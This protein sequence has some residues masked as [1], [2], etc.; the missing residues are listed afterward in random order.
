MLKGKTRKKPSR[1]FSRALASQLILF[2]LISFAPQSLLV[3]K[4]H[5]EGALSV[6]L[7]S[8]SSEP[9]VPFLSK[10]EKINLPDTGGKS[11]AKRW[12]GLLL[13]QCL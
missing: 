3:R 5:R 6:K 9:S 13:S 2:L 10:R 7:R 8:N 12:K 11:A 1:E 4:P